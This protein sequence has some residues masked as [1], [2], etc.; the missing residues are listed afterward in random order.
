MMDTRTIEETAL[1]AWPALT[2]ILMDGW[3]LRLARGHTKRANSLNALAP[4]VALDAVLPQAERVFRAAGLRPV[5]RLSPLCPDDADDMLARRG[6]AAADPTTVMTAA[7]GDHRHDPEV[8]IAAGLTAGWAVGF[9][10]ANNVPDRHRDTHD[11]ML[12]NLALPTAFATLRRHGQA[13]AHGLAVA[14]RGMVGL[15][16]IV[17]LPAARRRGA[18]RLMVQTLMAW[19]R[20]Q[21]ATRAYLQVVDANAPARA[22]YAGL[23]FQSAYGYHYRLGPE[24]T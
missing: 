3:V 21:G 13:I 22:L 20:D 24:G 9:A 4:T 1:N 16:D 18:G 6:Y 8:E 5:V 15:F 23:G 10:A 14:E 17:T 11:R 2:T 7:I 12:G 19:G